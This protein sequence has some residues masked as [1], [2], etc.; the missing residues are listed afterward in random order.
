MGATEMWLVRHGESVANVIATAA[1]ARGDEQ[2]VV[3]W[4]DADVPLSATGEQQAAALGQWV[5]EHSAE[6]VPA[7]AWSS[8]YLRA[9]QTLGIALAKAGLDLPMRVDE[10]LRDRELGILDLLTSVGVEARHPA[11]AERRRWLGKFYY[12]PPGG[13]SWADVAL[14]IRS[15]LRDVDADHGD[16][17]VLVVA[18]DAVVMLFLYVCAELSEEELMDFAVENA[19]GNA[20][21][22]RLVRPSGSGRWEV[23]SFVEQGHLD[24]FDVAATEHQGDTDDTAEADGDGDAPAGA[25]A[26]HFAGTAG[27]GGREEA[28]GVDV[29]R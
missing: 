5:A 23:A 1:Q 16:G 4:R 14:R 10:R 11:E 12:R 22:T 9:R 25:E 21:V 28:G 15:F 26:D 6:G 18:H 2:I 17:T 7:V 20:T 27:A 24:E 19:V 13:E 8:T 29:E 3:E